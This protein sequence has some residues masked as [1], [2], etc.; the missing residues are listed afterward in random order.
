MLK[1]VF[2]AAAFAI[3]LAAP[4]EAQ[5]GA[6]PPVQ[7]MDCA[8]M[9]AEM[10]AAGA[11]MHGQFDQE[12]F[13]ADQ[14]A[15]DADMARRRREAAASAGVATAAC[16]IPG[17]GIPC[18]AMQQAQV[19]RAQEGMQERQ[20]LQ[21]RQHDRIQQ[22][23]AGIDQNRMMAMSHRFEALGCQTPQ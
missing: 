20:E 2:A 22:S 18:M 15:L 6:L 5:D 13:A 19:A 12:G 9:T 1:H 23:M 3:C 16:V 4:A 14:A 21:Q 11:Q 17:M 8:A 7:S 10:T